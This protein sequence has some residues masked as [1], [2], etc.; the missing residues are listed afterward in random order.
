[1]GNKHSRSKSTS[2][3]FSPSGGG[4]EKKRKKKRSRSVDDSQSRMPYPEAGGAVP[5][6]AKPPAREERRTSDLRLTIYRSDRDLGRNKPSNFTD[7]SERVPYTLHRKSARFPSMEKPQTLP[8][9]FGR[10]KSAAFPDRHAM[11][12]NGD[13]PKFP[14]LA[15]KEQPGI[16]RSAGSSTRSM[17]GRSRADSANSTIRACKYL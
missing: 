11:T 15:A 2:D 12:P 8:R 3:S 17:K 6:R 16:L 7:G 4:S 13:V 10:S 1:M 5:Y 9:N 14:T